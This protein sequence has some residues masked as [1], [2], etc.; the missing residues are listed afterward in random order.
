MM[1][2]IRT[3][4]ASVMILGSS[5]RTTRIASGRGIARANSRTGKERTIAS[6]TPPSTIVRMLGT[7]RRA[8]IN[9]RM[10]TAMSATWS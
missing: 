6:P 10:G 5:N 7:I 9:R 4:N 3:T 8:R 2:G 1:K